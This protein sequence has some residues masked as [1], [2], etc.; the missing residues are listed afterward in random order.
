MNRWPESSERK[1]K[2]WMWTWCFGGPDRLEH[3]L[4]GGRAVVVERDRVPAGDGEAV[5]VVAELGEHV[6]PVGHVHARLARPAC[7]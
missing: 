3:R 2:N 5:A 1:M 6:P 7:P 4:E